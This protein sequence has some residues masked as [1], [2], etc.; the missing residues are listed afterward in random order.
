MLNF[1]YSVSLLFSEIV[2]PE[3]LYEEY[4]TYPRRFSHAGAAILG[5]STGVLLAK[6]WNLLDFVF[7]RLDKY[8]NGRERKKQKDNFDSTH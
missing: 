7:R 8:L 6:K 5:G 4:W 3:F 2:L 1:T